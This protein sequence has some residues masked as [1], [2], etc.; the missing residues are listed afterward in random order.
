[1]VEIRRA[2]WAGEGFFG[3]LRDRKIGFCNIDQPAVS[4]SLGPT[5]EATSPV[6]Y[7]RLH[8]RN[9]EEWF[10]EGREPFR[11]YDYLYAEEELTPWVG[12]I[13]RIAEQTADVFIIA[14][15][16]YRGKGPLAALTLLAMITGRPV[17]APPDL[18]AAYP[19]SASRLVREAPAQPG[20]FEG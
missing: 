14:N 20:L 11:R 9:A 10:R 17:A 2:D 6:G 15:N 16:H 3:F 7:V 5:E 18:A 8:G 13:G 4:R 19:S 1:V 12:R